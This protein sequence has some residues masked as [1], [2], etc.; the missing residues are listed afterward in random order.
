[1]EKNSIKRWQKVLRSARRLYHS[2]NNYRMSA[3]DPDFRD[4]SLLEYDKVTPEEVNDAK[5]LGFMKQLQLAK[6][7]Y[8][9]KN[10]KLQLVAA[11]RKERFIEQDHKIVP[12]G[13]LRVMEGEKLVAMMQ[14]GFDTLNETFCVAYRNHENIPLWKPY[15]TVR[16]ERYFGALHPEMGNKL[17]LS[18]I[19]FDIGALKVGQDYKL[20]ICRVYNDAVRQTFHSNTYFQNSISSPKEDL[21][22]NPKNYFGQQF[23]LSLS[24]GKETIMTL[25]EATDLYFVFQSFMETAPKQES[26]YFEKQEFKKRFLDSGIIVLAHLKHGL[27]LGVQNGTLQ[28]GKHDGA[29]GKGRLRW[30]NFESRMQSG[31]LSAIEKYYISKEVISKKNFLVETDAISLKSDTNEAS[32]KKH[33]GTGKWHFLEGKH[34]RSAMN[35]RPVDDSVLEHINRTYSRS[36]NFQTAL[37]KLQKNQTIQTAQVKQQ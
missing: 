21:L 15:D 34:H 33:Y 37:A 17:K 27:R 31:S 14:L 29:N 28:I 12:F 4:F 25:T 6:R 10:L 24:Q 16:L 35:S 7:G 11:K 20:A 1:M 3:K 18:H 5:R 19:F 32:L 22:V 36:T 13:N 23:Y 9:D 2:V 26:I 30:E 8:V